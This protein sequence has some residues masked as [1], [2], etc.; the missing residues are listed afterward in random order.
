MTKKIIEL[1]LGLKVEVY[2]NGEIHTL[3]HNGVRR[4]GRVDNRKGKKLSPG[5]DRDGYYKV[6][7]SHKGV[8]KSYP[9]HRL[10][11]MAFIPNPYGKETVNHIDGD[12][13]NNNVSNLEWASQKENQRH[14]WRTGLANY[15]RDNLG[16]FI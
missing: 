1:F 9:V 13:T 16:R 3:D 2:D 14:K 10:V 4:N 6:V 11:A 15:K 5:K 8:R 12:K 7:F